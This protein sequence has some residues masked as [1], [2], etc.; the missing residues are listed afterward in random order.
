MLQV[1]NSFDVEP[2]EVDEADPEQEHQI[3]GVV[4]RKKGNGGV[5]V[6][7]LQWKSAKLSLPEITW[8]PFDDLDAVCQDM[9]L[10]AF[11]RAATEQWRAKSKGKQK[12]RGKKRATSIPLRP[13]KDYSL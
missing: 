11:P 13:A 4:G 12:K 3:M 2:S 1:A 9:V 6:Y 8:E 7:G 5:W 10:T